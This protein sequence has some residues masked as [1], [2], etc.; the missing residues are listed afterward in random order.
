MGP[1]IGLLS[2]NKHLNS[3]RVDR[4]SFMKRDK[5]LDRIENTKEPSG[6]KLAELM[7]GPE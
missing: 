4:A 7:L 3:N 2:L 5:A 1:A 6:T